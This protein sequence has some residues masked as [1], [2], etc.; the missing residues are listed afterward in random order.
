[1]VADLEVAL[2]TL[3]FALTTVAAASDLHGGVGLHI[4]GSPRIAWDGDRFTGGYFGGIAEMSWKR[5]VGRGQLDL[6][7][8]GTFGGPGTFLLDNAGGLVGSLG[9]RLGV[10]E[11]TGVGVDLM[12]SAGGAWLFYDA[13]P[14]RFG[15]GSPQ[16]G[17]TVA[18]RWV[19][20]KPIAVTASFRHLAGANVGRGSAISRTDLGLGV[21]IR[22]F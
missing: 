10:L 5:F 18:P 13:G 20:A 16:L 14:D 7:L 21:M 6:A 11:Q 15:D 22:V 4:T 2:V 9:V 12:A 17:F 3:A 8:P 19:V 1:M